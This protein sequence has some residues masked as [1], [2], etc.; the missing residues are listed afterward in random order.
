MNN[1]HHPV[2]QYATIGEIDQVIALWKSVGVYNPDEDQYH[3]LEKVVDFDAE[4]L[5]LLKIGENL[6]GSCMIV[7]H[8]HQTFIYR[9]G[10]HQDYQ[11][12]WLGTLLC[13]FIEK[14]LIAKWMLHPTLF[15]EEDN[16]LWK[17]FRSQ[18]WRTRLYSVDCFVKNLE[19]H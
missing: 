15:V 2:F 16:E 13:E 3:I 19:Q 8:P 12:Q 11:W 7:Y 18:Q 5:C 1:I 4:A 17:K 6:V 9:F 10:I 14:T